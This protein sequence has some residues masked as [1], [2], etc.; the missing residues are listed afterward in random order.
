MGGNCS[1]ER[2]ANVQEKVDALET[3]RRATQF[4]YRMGDLTN[5]TWETRIK[6]GDHWTNHQRI[7]QTKQRREWK[8][9]RWDDNSSDDDIEIIEQRIKSRKT[10]FGQEYIWTRWL[11]NIHYDRIQG[12]LKQFLPK[13]KHF[14]HEHPTALYQKQ[15][16]HWLRQITQQRYQEW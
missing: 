4:K 13:S 16:L 10:I 9:L 5:Q 3:Q 1:C 2:V 14:H 15:K 6:K 7:L 8:P 11:Q 12:E